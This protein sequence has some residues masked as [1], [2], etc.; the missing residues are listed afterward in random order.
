MAAYGQAS[1]AVTTPSALARARQRA[2]YVPDLL[3]EASRV[4]NTVIA[5]LAWTPQA[6]NR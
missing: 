2:A 4:A 3:V 1:E 6:R 5:R